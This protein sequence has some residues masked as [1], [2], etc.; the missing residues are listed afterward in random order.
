MFAYKNQI[1]GIIIGI[2]KSHLFVFLQK[3]KIGLI[4]KKCFKKNTFFIGQLIIGKFETCF[5]NHLRLKITRKLK[6]KFFLRTEPSNGFFDYN[7]FNFSKNFINKLMKVSNIDFFFNKISEVLEFKIAN[8]TN[9]YVFCQN[10]H[11]SLKAFFINKLIA[12]RYM[13]L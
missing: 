12:L 1:L 5:S 13:S 8:G 7:L 4:S 3:N 11:K 6:T 9:G 2:K 10:D